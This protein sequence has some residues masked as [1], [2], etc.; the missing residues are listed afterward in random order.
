MTE[1]WRA[2]V[3]AKVGAL[4]LDVD[5][6]GNSTPLALVGPNGSGKTTLLRILCGAYKPTWGEITLCG[7][8]LWSSARGIDLIPEARSM[9]YVPQGYGLFRHR[10]VLDNVAFGLSTRAHRV[11]RAER[12]RVAQAMLQELECGELGRRFPDELSG[13]E[14]QRVALARALVINPK[15]LLLDEPLSA[16][17]VGTRRRL[18]SVLAGRLRSLARPCVVVTHDARDV[19]QLDAHEIGRAHV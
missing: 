1:H 12:L 9:G 2:Q 8:T 13:G 11:H 19:A 6:S 17:D 15:M 10:N 7:V 4:Q 14:Q 5:L 16:L 3:Q 18:R